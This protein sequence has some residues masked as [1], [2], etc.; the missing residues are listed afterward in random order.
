MAAAEIAQLPASDTDRNPEAISLW[1]KRLTSLKSMRH[2]LSARCIQ[3][4]ARRFV[5]DARR[6]SALRTSEPLS[7]FIVD[8]LKRWQVFRQLH[9]VRRTS[10]TWREEA[11]SHS[12]PRW[13]LVSRESETI[14]HEDHELWAMRAERGVLAVKR[15]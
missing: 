5:G 11:D 7:T 13:K 3:Q 12:E 8:A 10:E 9:R 6:E 1:H 15:V 2:P 4:V 14:L